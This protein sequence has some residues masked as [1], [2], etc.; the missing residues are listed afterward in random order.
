[1]KYMNSTIILI[2]INMRF[3][4]SDNNTVGNYDDFTPSWFKNIGFSISTSLI[5]QVFSLLFWMGYS[6]IMPA[7]SRCWDRSLR[8][9]PKHTKTKT[10]KAYFK[11]YSGDEFHLD[12]SYTEIIN[13]IYFAFSF[14]PLL[15]IVYPLSMLKLMFL[16]W[17]DRYLRKLFLP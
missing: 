9:H 10:L 14:G 8:C 16:L 17:S 7:I 2:F 11:L 1:M 4:F 13:T 3:R 12:F 15:P 5:L 6:L